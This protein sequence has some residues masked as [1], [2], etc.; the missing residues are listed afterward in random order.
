MSDSI[1]KLPKL[2]PLSVPLS[3]RRTFSVSFALPEQSTSTLMSPSMSTLFRRR[4]RFGVTLS[5]RKLS[6]VISVCEF[7]CDSVLHHQNLLKH[8]QSMGMKMD[9]LSWG[10]A[11]SGS[12]GGEWERKKKRNKHNAEM[13]G[14][15]RWRKKR[16]KD[17]WLT[18]A[19]CN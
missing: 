10:I 16:E 11:F 7:V 15:G 19:D 12:V 6:S 5:P 13:D 14:S 17:V 2:P 4:P 3:L 1:W 9:L 18:A 8:L